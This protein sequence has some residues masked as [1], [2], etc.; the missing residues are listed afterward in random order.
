MPN[1]ENGGGGGDALEVGELAE[2]GARG[3]DAEAEP[4]AP[5]D[6]AEDRDEAAADEGALDEVE[7]ERLEDGGGEEGHETRP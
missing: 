2:G 4:D 5:D 1:T 6:A 7:R 3:D